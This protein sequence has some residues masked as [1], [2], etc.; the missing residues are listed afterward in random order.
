VERV[1]APVWAA[2]EVIDGRYRLIGLISRGGMAD[3]FEAEDERLRRRV[4]LKRF[5]A[6]PVADRARFESEV[7]LLASLDHPNLVRVFDAGEHEGDAF[8][9]LELVEGPTV[10]D[11]MASGRIGAREVA[12]VGGA[13]A[14]A[15][16]YV[17]DR[18]VVHRDVTPAN[19]LCDAE[20][21]PRLADFGI[22][23]VLDATRLTA[24]TVT[25]GTAAYMAPEQVQGGDVTGAADVYS[26]GL[27][28]LELLT[29]QRAFEGT[30]HEVAM[31][32]LVRAPDTSGAPERWQHLLTAMTDLAPGARPSA[33]DVATRLEELAGASAPDEDRTTTALPIP[34]PAGVAGVAGDAAT[35][36]LATAPGGTRPMPIAL[37]PDPD[38]GPRGA[39]TAA[40]AFAAGLWARRALLAVV[41]GV[42]FLVLVAGLAL[43]GKDVEL[44]AT[45][46]A[47]STTTPT[48]VAPTTT[49]PPTT[50]APDP[51]GKDHGKGK[52]GKDD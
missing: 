4:A 30:M 43:G 26:L 6:D 41:A 29:G 24:A 2:D 37:A 23:R 7:T 42:A 14:A 52:K 47:P 21:R 51:Q 20:G 39:S 5:R 45:S 44:P 8:L 34:A 36:V 25:L 1:V 13:V 11:R 18:G 9:V 27:I 19:I 49:A 33:V 12:A 31:A 28:L 38:P 3:V 48:T 22:A 16:A 10:A 50:Q 15:L 17:H 32:R 40:R 35:Q 46:T